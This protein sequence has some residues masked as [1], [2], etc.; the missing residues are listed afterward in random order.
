MKWVLRAQNGIWVGRPMTAGGDPIACCKASREYFVML[1]H[2][3]GLVPCTVLYLCCWST[4]SRFPLQSFFLLKPQLL[5]ML[6]SNN[7][8]F[9]LVVAKI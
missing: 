7:I 9:T 8:S 5:K 4:A 6:L 2:W 1:A 3:G